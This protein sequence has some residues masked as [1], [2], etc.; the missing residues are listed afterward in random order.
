[1]RV[2]ELFAGIGGFGLGLERAGARVA[3][4]VEIDAQARAVQA[5]HWP[6]VQ[7]FNDVREV[8]AGTLEAVDL[9]A[10][11]FPCQD[12]SIAGRRAVRALV[13][14]PS[15]PFRAAPPLGLR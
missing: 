8:G 1:M 6:G 15:N 5:R 12:L 14:V 7:R 13:G 9:V 3:W 10:G 4:Q 11:G 2:G